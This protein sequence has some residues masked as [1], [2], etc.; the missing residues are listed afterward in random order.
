MLC[1]GYQGQPWY[2]I[3]HFL[4]EYWGCRRA[5][6]GNKDLFNDITCDE[7]LAF[8]YTAFSDMSKRSAEYEAIK[9]RIEELVFSLLKKGKISRGKAAN[10]TGS[11]MRYVLVR[12]SEMG[13]PVFAEA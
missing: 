3:C 2:L 1:L 12:M 6:T 11:P 9:P 8:M 4:V 10:L 7:L 13:I 5:W